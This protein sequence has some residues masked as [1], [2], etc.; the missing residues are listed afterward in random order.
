MVQRLVAARHALCR[1]SHRNCRPALPCFRLTSWAADCGVKE[2]RLPQVSVR[3]AG[4]RAAAALLRWQPACELLCACHAG[5]APPS[6]LPMLSS[7][8]SCPTPPCTPFCPPQGTMR[9][10]DTPDYRLFPCL[11]ATADL[12]MM[13]KEVGEG[14]AVRGG[15]SG[16]DLRQKSGAEHAGRWVSCAETP[17]ERRPSRPSGCR[18]CL[19]TPRCGARWCR[20]CRCTACAS[21]WSGLSPTTARPTRCRRVRAWAWAW[22][23]AGGGCACAHGACQRSPVVPALSWLR[24]DVADES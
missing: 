3:A 10:T 18:R 9:S 21:C 11:R 14:W 20:A 13:P 16:V 2:D 5:V 8:L 22:V 6:L 1:L 19:Q 23:Q 24:C 12:L 7:L 4:L 15:R 17:P